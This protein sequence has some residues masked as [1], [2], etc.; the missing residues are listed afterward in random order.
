MI[1]T[2]LYQVER[3]LSN[4]FRKFQAGSH[5]RQTCHCFLWMKNEHGR[6]NKAIWPEGPGIL[7]ISVSCGEK[8]K[9]LPVCNPISWWLSV[10]I[11]LLREWA[12]CCGCWSLMRN[13]LPA[14]G[15]FWDLTTGTKKTHQ[16]LD[17]YCPKSLE[18]I[19]I[20][21]A[22]A[23][24]STVIFMTRTILWGHTYSIGEKQ[25]SFPPAWQHKSQKG[26]ACL[27]NTAKRKKADVENITFLLHFYKMHLR[28]WE[29]M[30]F[31]RF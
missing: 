21:F 12:W 31:M 26:A 25:Q 18:W 27:E 13:R 16:H 6:I 7:R 8:M 22:Y 3:F 5:S 11:G 17:T 1:T 4:Y 2:G 14:R 19:R 10:D 29:I 20:L 24:L 23:Q 28:I 9:H 15:Q 30:T